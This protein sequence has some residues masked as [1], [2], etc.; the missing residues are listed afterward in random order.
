[1]G[2]RL[3]YYCADMD[4]PLVLVKKFYSGKKF[5]TFF[6]FRMWI[7]YGFDAGEVA[8][9][10]VNPGFV[11]SNATWTYVFYF[12]LAFVVII[13]FILTASFKLSEEVSDSRLHSCFAFFKLTS[14]ITAGFIF[15]QLFLQD[16]REPLTIFIMV[17]TG[18]D[19]S[20]DFIEMA[21]GCASLGFN[22]VYPFEMNKSHAST[23]LE[24][25]QSS[26]TNNAPRK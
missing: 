6:L 18:A 24:H 15:F 17:V 11:Y 1:M 16:D 25:V 26:S 4:V 19:M 20:L 22:T 7:G 10:M 14:T 13:A 23:D 3:R 8:A 9:V 5:P 12:Y 2:Q 21:A